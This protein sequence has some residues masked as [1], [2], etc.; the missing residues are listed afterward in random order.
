MIKAH[1]KEIINSGIR[2]VD[3][4]QLIQDRLHREGEYLY[5]PQDIT[6][7]LEQYEHIYVCGAGK[8][9]APMAKAME[10]LLNDK[11]TGGE[12][13]VKYEHGT[14]LKYIHQYE[15]AHPIPDQAGL[16]ATQ[17]LMQTL[18]NLS[19]KD[20]VF[21]LVTGGGSALLES[22]PA[23]ISVDDLQ[24]LSIVLLG[25]GATIHEI[26]CIRK[27][28]SQIKGGQLARLIHP[29]AC[30][31]LILSDVIG[32]D[33]SVIASGPTSPDSTTFS[34]A[35][36]II[37][38]Y[39][40]ENDIPSA[41]RDFLHAGASGAYPDTPK[42]GDPVF[43]K[44]K[45][46]I[47]GNNRLALGTAEACAKGFNYNTLVLTSMLQ[48]EARE[49]GLMIAGIIKEIQHADSP[50]SKPACLLLGGEP[51]VRITGKGKGGRNQELV[52]AVALSGIDQ[53]Y[54]FASVGTD[55]TDG[56]T[57]AAG[58]VVT[59]ETL[60]RSEKQGLNARAYLN[61]N[62]SYHFFQALDDLVKTGPTGTN[63]MDLILALVP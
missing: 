42:P 39:Q 50:V 44:V 24:R 56:P 43:S 17:S 21:M 12:I 49:I 53:P 61:N 28:I 5:L 7:N 32:D 16:K 57:D 26:N 10:E 19:E 31:S 14:D 35:L 47:I 59:H 27:H 34:D 9:T 18:N 45:N 37:E 36:A 63:V 1:A 46:M 23:A 38:K 58:A 13:I 15:A 41:I 6:V 48:G 40:I 51:T 29:A 4:Y 30:I 25:C 54:L 22:L 2:A 3:P 20:C 33:L 55:G 11:V 62:D 8:G 52:L 60:N